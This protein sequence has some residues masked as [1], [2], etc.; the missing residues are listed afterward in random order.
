MRYFLVI[1]ILLGISLLAR[2]NPFEPVKSFSETG[3]AVYKEDTIKEFSSI[4]IQLPSSARI[5][6]KVEFHFQNL[7]G[8]VQSKSVKI[9]KKVD[10]QDKLVVQ[11]LLD[12]NPA[13]IKAEKR[14]RKKTI[15]F[16][17]VL[18]IEIDGKS[19]HLKTKDIK[20]RDFLI[21]K[22]HKI[23]VDFKREIS[24]YTQTYNLKK[25]YFTSIRI[26]KH[27]GYYRVA[28]ELDGKYVYSKKK[29]KEGY[30][31]ILR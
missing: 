29:T 20:I 25:R 19:I 3:K 30:L 17:D 23:I 8:S 14:S 28:I 4:D 24:F 26:G 13:P 7:D 21:T 16:K 2:D 11:K 22:P 18:L 10:W 5:L 9:D 31:F 27:S 15:N 1:F 6:K 12:K